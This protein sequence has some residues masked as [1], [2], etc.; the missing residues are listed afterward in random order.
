MEDLEVFVGLSIKVGNVY[1]VCDEV[2]GSRLGFVWSDKNSWT[3]E[4]VDAQK[5]TICET[6]EEC[7]QGRLSALHY[8]EREEKSLQARIKMNLKLDDAETLRKMH[9]HCMQWLGRLS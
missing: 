5:V 2:C 3:G 1:G 7:E 9:T 6:E 4:L 8:F